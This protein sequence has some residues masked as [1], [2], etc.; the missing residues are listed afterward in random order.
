[1]KK[2][3]IV[4]VL[5]VAAFAVGFVPQYLKASQLWQE[6]QGLQ[7]ELQKC[8]FDKKVSD[9]KVEF[10]FV[11]LEVMRNNYGV[12]AAGSAKWFTE[13]RDFANQTSDAQ[14][15]SQIEDALASRDRITAGLATADPAVRTEIQDLLLKLKPL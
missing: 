13:L 2:I 6:A 12:A 8:Q 9:L 1:M 5:L 7:D 11:Y 3:I 4:F 10:G 14:L 15:K